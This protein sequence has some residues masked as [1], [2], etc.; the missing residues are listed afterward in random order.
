MDQAEGTGYFSPS[1]YAEHLM[2]RL[3]PAHTYRT[4]PLTE[5]QSGLYPIV[6]EKVG[7]DELTP[8]DL[9]PRTEWVQ[10]T[11]LGT[12]EKVY[13]QAADHATVVGY[14]C[15]PH[16]ASAP[17]PVM[18][19]LQGHTSG[20]H[21]SIGRH[22][23]DEFVPMAVPNDQDFAISAMRNGFAALCIEQRSFGL[24]GE[25]R[26]ALVSPHPCH[27]AALQALMLGQTLVGQRVFDVDRGIDFLA[28]RDEIDLTRIGVMGNSGGGMAAIYVAALLPRISFAMP[29]CAFCEFEYSMMAMYH[30]ADNYVP[31][32]MNVCRMSD[33][34]GLFAPKPLVVVA[35]RDDPEF[36]LPGVRLAFERLKDIY[37]AGDAED[38]CRLVIGEGAHR[39]YAEQGWAALIDLLR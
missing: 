5:W 9:S 25:R 15:I 11:P 28:T 20:M 4:G 34:L 27:D 30:C 21:R 10:Q 14:L 6:R 33:I 32:I 19:C 1:E 18:I 37:R 29:S 3:E 36:P 17:Y 23:D 31:G 22:M 8:V 13:F 12:I 2:A 7:L 35:G 16:G 38:R 24:R 26:Q 39:F